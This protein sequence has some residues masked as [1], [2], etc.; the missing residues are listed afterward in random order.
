MRDSSTG[1]S[2][3]KDSCSSSSFG[4]VMPFFEFLG[5][6]KTFSF[7]LMFLILDI[8]SDILCF[9][10][11][12]FLKLHNIKMPFLFLKFLLL[13]SYLNLRLCH[14]FLFILEKSLLVVFLSCDIW[15]AGTVPA[16]LQLK[17]F[18]GGLW[19]PSISLTRFMLFCFFFL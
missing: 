12:L 2:D 6:D 4:T 17:L 8:S 18:F 11:K 15:C 9:T 7:I 3:Q 16:T 5:C 1:L 13:K 14:I 19:W 10:V